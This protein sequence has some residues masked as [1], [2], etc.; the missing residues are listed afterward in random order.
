MT[1]ARSQIAPGPAPELELTVTDL[2]PLARGLARTA[3]GQL[4]RIPGADLGERL[5][6]ALVPG[7]RGRLLGRIVGLL[8]P[9]PWRTDPACPQ[10][11]SCPGCQLR[12]LTGPRQLTLKREL[13]LRALTRLGGVAPALVEEAIPH[14]Q[15][16]GQRI[17]AGAA[18]LPDPTT[19]EGLVLG[20]RPLPGGSGRPIDLARCPAQ[21]PQ[22]NQLLAQA[23]RTLVE[24]G[25]PLADR[26][27]GTGLL[28]HVLA[29][30]STTG[31]GRLCLAVARDGL[32]DAGGLPYLAEVLAR[33]LLPGEPAVALLLDPLP[34][35]T[36]ATSSGKA[37]LLRGE[38][39][40]SFTVGDTLLTA[41]EGAWTPL[42]PGAA[43]L[44]VATVARL[45]DELGDQGDDGRLLEIGCGVGTLTLP[46]A[47]RFRE[48]VGVDASRVAIADAEENRQRAGIMG[49]RFR[50][51]WAH[52]AVR[53][54][55]AGGQRFGTALLHSIRLPYGPAV[56]DLLPTLGVRRLVYVSPAASSLARDLGVLQQTG[57]ELQRVVPVDQIPATAHLMGVAALRRVG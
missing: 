55:A 41:R 6:V 52:H 22:V 49:L 23:A 4:V 38:P 35:R 15:P 11:E 19:G 46:L 17:R 28:R 56:L 12:H 7:Q 39:R 13:L 2:D 25:L 53:R 50:T 47:R 9:S 43:H 33:R 21:H 14:P 29:H 34:R 1:Q 48:G 57:W 37:L 24:L 32:A 5:R 8:E 42:S 44:L 10:A 16:D 51:G 27:A 3:T 26:V 45:L 36:H 54:L 31:G 20:M 40:V 18:C 30:G